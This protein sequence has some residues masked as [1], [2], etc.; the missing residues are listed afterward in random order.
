MVFIV[1]KPIYKNEDVLVNIITRTH[2]RPKY[3]QVCRESILNQTHKKINHIVGSDTVCDY[4][5][6]I[7]LELLPVRYPVAEYGSY[8][9]PWNLHLNELQKYAKEGWVMFLDDDDKFVYNDSISTILNYV[10]SEDEI[11]FWRVDI[12]G[13]IVPDDNGF[14]KIIAG[15]ISGIGFMFHTKY[16]PVDWGSWNFGDYR[17]MTQLVEKK[18]QQ[19]W[20]NL[21]LTQTQG[22]PNLGQTPIG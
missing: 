19:K 14:G 17:V 10:K 15:N 18:L 20:I 8:P 5:D 12:N 4:H 7:K 21:V 9:A 13:W 1:R 3:F 16:L 2:N 6:C 11:I 22:R